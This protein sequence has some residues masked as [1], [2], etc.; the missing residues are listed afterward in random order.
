MWNKLA[1]MPITMTIIFVWIVIW[2]LVK[3]GNALPALT[4]K[5]FSQIGNQ[6][7]R[8]VTAGL[9]HVHVLHLIANVC[10]MFWL[11]YL[12]EEHMGSVKFLLVGFV[13][14]VV[15][16]VIFLAIYHNST[17]S[18]G[19]ST[20]NFALCGFGL[21]MQ[22]LSPG[23]PRIA[24]GTWSGNWLAV[25]MVVGNIPLMSFMNL[26]TLIVHAIAFALGVVAA[27]VFHFCG[28]K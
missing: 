12:Y 1:K 26:T 22:F 19:G 17:G 14:A 9:T 6:Y 11:G 28:I 23:F 18:Y 20:Y 13:C 25:Y 21:A 5:G 16:Q 15:C 3:V 4:G 8:F 7:Y 10:A 2:A 24:L 27:L